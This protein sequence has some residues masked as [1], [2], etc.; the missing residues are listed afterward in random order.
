MIKAMYSVQEVKEKIEKGIPLILAGDE[1][2]LSQLPKG[3]WIGGTIPYFM[4]D[5]G[6]EESK[7]KISV[8]EIPDYALE[9]KTL[10]YTEEN[11]ENVYSD[12]FENGFSLILIPAF[13][14]VHLSF[15]VNA[16]YYSYFASRS[17]LGWVTGLHLNDLG[18]TTPK[19]Y[20]G[21][22]GKFYEDAA[23]V[24]HV[25]LDFDKFAEIGIINIF[26]QGEGDVIEFLETGFSAEYALVNGEKVKFADYV[27]NN[28][29]DVKLPLAADYWGAKI[30]VS[31]QSI[32]KESGVVNFYAP[33][34]KEMQYKHASPILNYVEQFTNEIPQTNNSM[35]FSCNC[36]LNYLYSELE[37][38]KTADIKGPITFGEIAYQ[39]LN[40][41]LVYL[42]I[43]EI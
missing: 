32:D 14:K 34:F 19:I 29:L 22:E 26:N 4:G 33:V 8:M 41:T 11:I 40:Q 7:D 16:P 2:L 5:D 27:L 24:M 3:N 12:A 42:I 15:S 28:N 18:K 1:N 30:N 13:T 23:I 38:K 35:I 31:F 21:M 37:G 10:I 20:S 36:I 43:H 25:S 6:G 17:L 39:L 9:T